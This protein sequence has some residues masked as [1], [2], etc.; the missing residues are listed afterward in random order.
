MKREHLMYPIIAI[1][2]IV[3]FYGAFHLARYIHYN[4]AYKDMVIE[5]TKVTICQSV[6]YEYLTIDCSGLKK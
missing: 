5:T 3:F 6:K 4:L 1:L 2:L